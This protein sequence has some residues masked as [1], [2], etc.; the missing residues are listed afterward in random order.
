MDK[1]G[2]MR[3]WRRNKRREESKGREKG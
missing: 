3:R 2:G 1:R